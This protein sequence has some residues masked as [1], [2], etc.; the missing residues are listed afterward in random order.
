MKKYTGIFSAGII[1]LLWI[2][3]LAFWI[4]MPLD[5]GNPFLFL[6]ILVQTHLYTGLFISSHDAIHG[7]VSKE[8]P[9]LN[10]AIGRLCATLFAFNNYTILRKKHQHHHAY[11][12]TADDPDVHQG[13][14]FIWWFKFLFQYVHWTQILAMAIT[15]NLLK[16]WF[17]MENIILFWELPAILATLQLFYFGTYLPHRG[18]HEPDNKHQSRSQQKNHIWAF[19]SCYNFGYHYEHHDKPYLPWW[20]LAE[21]KEQNSQIS[22]R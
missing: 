2:L 9:Q 6:A 4:Q 22:S 10:H 11:V 5:W 1:I 21:V 8:Y 20:K 3:H 12:N 13:N 16:I 18:V 7:V 15:Y 14:F 17:P 19:L